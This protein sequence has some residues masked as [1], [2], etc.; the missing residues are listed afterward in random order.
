[1][2][3]IR[4]YLGEDQTL[5][6]CLRY[7][8]PL[9]SMSAYGAIQAPPQKQ[10]LHR[11]TYPIKPPLCLTTYPVSADETPEELKQYLYRV[12]SDELEGEPDYFSFEQ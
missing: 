10:S 8:T 6:T 4:G 1:V 12:F 3:V 5:L 9:S 2:E 7:F 11:H